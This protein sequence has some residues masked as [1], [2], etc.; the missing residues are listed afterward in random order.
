MPFRIY[1][2][3][4]SFLVQQSFINRAV[5]ELQVMLVFISYLKKVCNQSPFV[6]YEAHISET[7]DVVQT[8]LCLYIASPIIFFYMHV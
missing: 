2:S 4:S 5:I 1:H 3:L 6:P 7:T 8:R